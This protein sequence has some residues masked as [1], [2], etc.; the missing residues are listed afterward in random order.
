M[1]YPLRFILI[2]SVNECE[3][4]KTHCENSSQD[5]NFACLTVFHKYLINMAFIDG[6]KLSLCQEQCCPKKVRSCLGWLFDKGK[7]SSSFSLL[8]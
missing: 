6:V 1:L 4:L 5:L 8:N 3:K 2:E 7:P